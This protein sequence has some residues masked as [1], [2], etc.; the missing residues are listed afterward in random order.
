MSSLSTPSRPQRRSQDTAPTSSSSSSAAFTPGGAVPIGYSYLGRSP[1]LVTPTRKGEHGR[2]NKNSGDSAVRPRFPSSLSHS[3]FVRSEVEDAPG[4]TRSKTVPNELAIAPR[5]RPRKNKPSA[6][7]HYRTSAMYDPQPLSLPSDPKTWSSSHVSQYLSHILSLVPTPVL[8]TLNEFVAREGINGK[9][10]LRIREA[11]LAEKGMN[12]RWRKLMAEASRRL[13]R[14]ALRKRI[15]GDE[16]VVE[17]HDDDAQDDILTPGQRRIMTATLKRI[18]DRKQVQGLIAALESPGSSKDVELPDV[19]SPTRSGSGTRSGFVQR[20]ANSFDDLAS[21]AAAGNET[22]VSTHLRRRGNNTSDESLSPSLSS[23]TSTSSLYSDDLTTPVE[24]LPSID[25]DTRDDSAWQPLDQELVDA[26]LCA[27]SDVEGAD[28]GSVDGGECYATASVDGGECYATASVD[29]GECYATASVDSGQCYATASMDS[30]SASV[31]TETDTLRM[32]KSTERQETEF[33][34][35]HV[36][37]IFGG[38]GGAPAEML[39]TSAAPTAETVSAPAPQPREEIVSAPPP[40]TAEVMYPPAPQTAEK[41]STPRPATPAP[42]TVSAPTPAPPPATQ[43]TKTLTLGTTKGRKGGKDLLALFEQASSGD[44]HDE[45]IELAM[46]KYDSNHPHTSYLSISRAEAQRILSAMQGGDNEDV[47]VDF[48][49]EEGR[50]DDDDEDDVSSLP[51][52]WLDAIRSHLDHVSMSYVV[53]L[54][55]GIGFVV[56]SEVLRGGR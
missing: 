48:A 25:F 20:Q 36:G 54:G 37:S 16:Q 17:D 8:E 4:L 12:T 55:A 39:S 2:A 46:D 3:E 45:K 24:E 1:S 47:D 35:P 10:F 43:R 44:D 19:E 49:L 30:G 11:D 52:S 29:R 31:D 33:K 51:T 40:P 5:P 21:V 27:S 13:R 23:S 14:D 18:R 15:W 56:V 32:G 41:T 9:A 26:I 42:S 6:P 7:S 50:R 22:N 38:E 53:G 28:V 34:A